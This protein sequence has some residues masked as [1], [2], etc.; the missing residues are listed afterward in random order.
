MTNHLCSCLSR[1]PSTSIRSWPALQGE[2]Q[3][4]TSSSYSMHHC[5][6][7]LCN[8]HEPKN[9][10]HQ[11][12]NC[13]RPIHIHG[14]F[15]CMDHTWTLITLPLIFYTVCEMF[16]LTL[17]PGFPLRPEGPGKPRGPLNERNKKQTERWRWWVQGFLK[18]TECKKGNIKGNV[19][20]GGP[21]SPLSPFSPL[22]PGRPWNKH[23]FSKTESI[24][25]TPQNPQYNQNLKKIG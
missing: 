19:L 17:F 7:C 15:N 11:Y 2:T 18:A 5:V 13:Y 24:H 9:T 16:S 21:F 14:E 1:S 23:T 25:W 12:R 3:N 20:T 22:G 6:E 4:T 10:A 8:I